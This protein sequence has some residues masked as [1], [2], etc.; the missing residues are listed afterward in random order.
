MRRRYRAAISK[1]DVTAHQ[2]C[3]GLSQ[4]SRSRPSSSECLNDHNR[5]RVSSAA[6]RAVYSSNIALRLCDPTAE[7]CASP[8]A[9]NRSAVLKSAVRRAFLDCSNAIELLGV[10]D[11][12]IWSLSLYFPVAD[13]FLSQMWLPLLYNTQL[14]PHPENQDETCTFEPCWMYRQ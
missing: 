6:W 9:P 7:R 11:R 5:L 12:Q 1:N 2:S 14:S 13:V 10:Q 8:E 3:E 4:S